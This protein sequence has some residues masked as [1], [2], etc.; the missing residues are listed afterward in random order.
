MPKPHHVTPPNKISAQKNI[1]SKRKSMYYNLN[2]AKGTTDPRLR[3][4]KLY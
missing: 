4:F 1:L 3:V 2:I